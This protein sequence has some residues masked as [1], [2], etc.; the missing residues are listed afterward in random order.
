MAHTLTIDS[1]YFNSRIITINLWDESTDLI[2]EN[3]AQKALEKAIRR[4]RYTFKEKELRLSGLMDIHVM[5]KKCGHHIQAQWR[6]IRILT[7]GRVEHLRK[8]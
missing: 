4:L 1:K 2:P 8:Q 7:N 5:D 3:V 6:V